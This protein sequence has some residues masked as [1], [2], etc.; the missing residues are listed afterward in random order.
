MKKLF[1]FARGCGHRVGRQ[2]RARRRHQDRDRGTDHR[3]RRRDRRAD[4][5]RR[6][7]GG[8]GHQCQGRR[9]SASNSTLTVGDDAC[10]PKQA[11]AV[12]NKFAVSGV[13][14]VAGHYC[15][16]TSIPASAVYADAGILQISPASTNPA[17][18]DDPAR[19]AGTISS[20]SA[21]ATT[22]R[23]RRRRLHRRA[24]QGQAGR[25][26][27]RQDPPT[28]T[29]LRMRRAR[30]CKRTASPP[31]SMTMINQGDKDFSA[32]VS[33]MKQANIA[34]IYFGGYYTEAGLIVR[35]SRDQGLKAPLIGGDALVTTE[36]WTITGNAG[37][38]HAHDLL[39]RSAQDR[40]SRSRSSPN[41][42]SRITT[43]RATRSTPMPRCRFSRR[44]P[45]RRNR[46]ISTKWRR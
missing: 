12:A 37:A 13:A 18:T 17:Y 6:R 10:D 30:R 40:R 7:T 45:R 43:P 29:A 4:A 22:C 1:A 15:S 11:V 39:A 34:V 5:P 25:D 26:H 35:Q 42:R 23:A 44:R 27:R 31:R 33:K 9:C 36:F 19:K 28:A 38:G 20:A 46:P 32:L 8:Q 41:S 16:S 3:L 21:A 2:S 24:F 14:F